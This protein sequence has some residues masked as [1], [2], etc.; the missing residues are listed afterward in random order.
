MEC[1]EIQESILDALDGEPSPERQRVIEAHVSSCAA[2]AQFAARQMAIDVTLGSALAPPAMTPM[3]RPALRA[4]LRH[5]AVTARRDTLPDFVHFASR[6]RN[7]CPRVDSPGQPVDRRQCRPD[8]GAPQ[9]RRAVS[10]SQLVRG[11]PARGLRPVP[12]RNTWILENLEDLRLRYE[13][14]LELGLGV[15]TFSSLLAPSARAPASVTSPH[16][17]RNVS[18][19]W[20]KSV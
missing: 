4:R 8:D 9:L 6:P 5:D 11:L 13:R 16:H 17:T 20:A 2:C 19:Y 3:S 12:S 10:D 7:A 18:T 15:R 1:H 14:G